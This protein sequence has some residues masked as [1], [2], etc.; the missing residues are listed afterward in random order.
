MGQQ[1]PNQSGQ[2]SCGC[3]LCSESDQTG[4]WRQSAALCHKATLAPAAKLR[5]IGPHPHLVVGSTNHLTS[6]CSNRSLLS[7]SAVSRL[8]LQRQ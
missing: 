5:L 8:P 3:P 2:A 4:A 7:P 6:D 1:R